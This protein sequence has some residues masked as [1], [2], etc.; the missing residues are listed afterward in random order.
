MIGFVLKFRYLAIIAVAIL[1]VH[2]IGLLGLAVF[3]TYQAY[4]AAFQG[5]TESGQIRPGIPIAESVDAA[6]FALVLIVLAMGTVSLY[7]TGDVVDPRIPSWMRVRSLSELKTLLWEAILLVL[8]MAAL[9]SI[10]AHTDQLGWDLLILPAAVLIL[11]A[12]L[13]LKVKTG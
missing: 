4:H 1:L 3:R 8:V 6:L 7:L 9:T 11:S 10:M 5:G 13:F 12:G 2:A